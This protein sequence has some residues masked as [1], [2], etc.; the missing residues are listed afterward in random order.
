MPPPDTPRT[1]GAAP[2]AAAPAAPRQPDATPAKA[3]A[4]EGVHLVDWL[5]FA[6]TLPAACVD[7][8]YVD[9]PFNTGK[10]QAM[11]DVAYEDRWPNMNAYL[12]WLRPR[13]AECH[14]LLRDSGSL[15][16]HCDWRSSHHLR[17]LL[18]EFFGPRHFVNHLVWS[19]G[20]GGSSPRRFARKHDDILF[21]G[22]TSGY[23]FKPP[24]VPAESRRLSGQMKKATDVL[25]VPSLNNMAKERTG[26]PTQ[27]PLAL[28]TLLIEAACPPD[29]VVA[30]FCCGSG[31]TLAAA[32][33]LGRRSLGCDVNADAVR[34]AR[35]RLAS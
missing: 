30:D 10:R 25:E 34:I 5:E 9:P 15:M 22:R 23:F 26:Y 13:L 19:Y 8:V 28:L 1:A 29:G 18:D 33:Q 20:L 2:P 14:R 31:T 4:L 27:K 24:L 35:Q 16:L 17:L 3:P 6:R 21:Y 7:F 32:R 11:D 12:D